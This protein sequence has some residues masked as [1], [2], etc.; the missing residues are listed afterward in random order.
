MSAD[1]LVLA[2]HPD[3][4]ELVIGGSIARFTDLGYTVVI[5]DMTRGEMGTRGTAEERAAEAEAGAA[6]LGVKTRLNLDLGDGQLL[7]STAA[8]TRVV[9]VIRDLRPT[10][11]L[12]HHWHDLHPDHSATAQI[13]RDTMYPSGFPK[14]PAAGEPWRPNEVLFFMGH[15][16]FEPD[17]VID[18]SKHHALKMEAVRCYASQLY[19]PDRD[20]MGTNIGRPDFLDRI[21][22]RAR[23][24]GTQIYATFGEPFVTL[25]P[26]PVQDPVALY[27][28][29][30]KI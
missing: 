21:E 15:F 8:R 23:F 9:E 17:L 20:A 5:C 27:K 24:Y 1:I 30:P 12:T 11:L 19:D 25:R 4:A 6:V 13:V 16:P 10:I 22:A 26:I 14:Y 2:A 18:T 28:D 7:T 3:D 29:Y